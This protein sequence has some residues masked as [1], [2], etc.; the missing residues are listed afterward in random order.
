MPHKLQKKTSS[1]YDA[2]AF[3][4]FFAVHAGPNSATKM[5]KGLIMRKRVP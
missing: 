2:A 1:L 5:G 3:D 4:T